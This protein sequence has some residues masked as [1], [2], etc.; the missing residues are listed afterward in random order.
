MAIQFP[1][2]LGLVNANEVAVVEP[3]SLPLRWTKAMLVVVAAN[4]VPEKA[5]K[6]NNEAKAN[7]RKKTRSLLLN[8]MDCPHWTGPLFAGWG[9]TSVFRL[10]FL[11][12]GQKN[13]LW[14]NRSQ[15][16]QR[17]GIGTGDG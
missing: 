1:A 12:G 7:A 6:L 16:V 8:T 2:V 5:V 3:A 15:R 4:A 14:H 10:G 13:N 9:L 11:L 17:T